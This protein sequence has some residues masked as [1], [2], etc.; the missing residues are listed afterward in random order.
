MF[1]IKL[2]LLATFAGVLLQWHSAMA[3]CADWQPTANIASIGQIQQK[4]KQTLVDALQ[5]GWSAFCK[6]YYYYKFPL[7]FFFA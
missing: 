4:N 3:N 6:Y 7:E 2:L 1:A 5:T